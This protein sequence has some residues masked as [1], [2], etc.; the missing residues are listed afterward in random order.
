MLVTY[1]T[2]IISFPI[3]IQNSVHSENVGILVV[4]SFHSQKYYRST[5]I[6]QKTGTQDRGRWTKDFDLDSPMFLRFIA[7]KLIKQGWLGTTP[8]IKK[9][10]PQNHFQIQSICKIKL[11]ICH[12]LSLTMT[13]L[14]MLLSFLKTNFSSAS[15]K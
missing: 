5:L 3:V 10:Y 12:C 7:Q 6:N 8:S 2:V 14:L 11:T 15:W 13:I 4:L 1:K 9:P